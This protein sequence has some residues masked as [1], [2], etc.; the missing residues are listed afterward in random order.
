M[1]YIDEEEKELMESF[2]KDE[3]Q[4]IEKKEHRKYIESAE[5]SVSKSKRINIRLTP[6]DLHAIQVKAIE[7]GVPYQTLI[8]SIIHKYTQGK[9]RAT[10]E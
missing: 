3:W 7:E 2:E 1:K 10:T 6:R 4:S 9:L 8:S 5:M